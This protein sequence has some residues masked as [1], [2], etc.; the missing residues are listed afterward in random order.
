MLFK[1]LLPLQEITILILIEEVEMMVALTQA[2]QME[3]YL[4]VGTRRREQALALLKDVPSIKLRPSHSAH[5][6]A[7]PSCFRP[8]QPFSAAGTG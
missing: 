4:V 3:D 5:A 6:E 8:T 2:L 7:H 1:R